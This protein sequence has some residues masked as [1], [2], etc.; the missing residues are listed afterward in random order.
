MNAA[1]I[2]KYGNLTVLD[3]IKDLDESDQDQSGAC[4]EWSIKDILAHITSYEHLLADVFGTFLGI[5][6]TPTLDRIRN[7]PNTFNDLEVGIRKKKSF[8]DILK[9]YNFAHDLVIE[10]LKKIPER[11]LTKIGMLPWYGK[12][13]SLDDYIVYTNYGHI[14]EHTA[15]IE[16]F[17]SSLS[18]L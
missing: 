1:D 5:D 13:Y 15:Q 3:S 9:E 7:D 8:E 12:E 14:R 11:T 18:S 2:I 6:A 4:G 10:R 17:R 16:L